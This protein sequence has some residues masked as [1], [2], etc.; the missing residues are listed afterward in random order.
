MDFTGF[1][2]SVG[3]YELIGL[4]GAALYVLAFA[5]AALDRMPSSAPQYYLIRLTAAGLVLIS[6]SD[7]FN[8]AAAAIQVAFIVI[9]ILGLTRHIRHTARRRSCARLENRKTICPEPQNPLEPL[10]KAQ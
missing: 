9:S 1:A 7:S 5:L 3:P 10:R 4:C 8:L 2:F 6:L